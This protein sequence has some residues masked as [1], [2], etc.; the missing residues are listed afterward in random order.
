MFL[1]PLYR[2]HVIFGVSL[3]VYCHQI[4]GNNNN[5][6]PKLISQVVSREGRVYSDVITTLYDV[7][8]LFPIDHWLKKYILKIGL[9][10]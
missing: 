2:K 3:E 5:N 1:I 4:W 7:E 10:I 9:K 8:R 6:T